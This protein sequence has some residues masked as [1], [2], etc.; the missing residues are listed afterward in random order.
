[1]VV[2]VG[3]YFGPV[4]IV[5]KVSYTVMCLWVYVNYLLVYKL[6]VGVD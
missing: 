5:T 1:M 2:D 3:V 6:M 4:C